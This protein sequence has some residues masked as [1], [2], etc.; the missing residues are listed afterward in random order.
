MDRCERCG[1][2]PKELWERSGKRLFFCGHHANEHR[3]AL[4]QQ[5]WVNTEVAR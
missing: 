2:A 5:G 1:A 3:S 4:R